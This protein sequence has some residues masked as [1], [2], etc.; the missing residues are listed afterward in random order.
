MR[1][2]IILTWSGVFTAASCHAHRDC[3]HGLDH[4]SATMRDLHLSS[5]VVVGS[6]TVLV[7]CCGAWSVSYPQ[8]PPRRVHEFG[9]VRN[10]LQF[11]TVQQNPKSSLWTLD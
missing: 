10:E 1:M 5:D 8:P 3:C 9:C 11:H 6:C 2:A 7:V 4:G